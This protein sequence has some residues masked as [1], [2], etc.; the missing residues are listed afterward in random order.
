MNVILPKQYRVSKTDIIIYTVAIVV[1]VVALTVIITMQFLGEGIFHKNQ[2]Q[3]ATEEEMLKLKTEFDNMFSNQFEGEEEGFKK[4]DNSKAV[5]FTNYENTNNVEGDYTLNVHI[6]EINSEDENLLKLNKEISETYKE[7][8]SKILTAK[9]KQMIY[10]V[11]Y[12]S[13]IENK[14]L[15]LIIRSN[16]KQGNQAQ[17]TVLQ[18]Y[19]YDLEKK[20]M[21]NLEE[22]L[23]KLNY[24]KNDVQEKINEEIV[25]EEKNSKNLQELGYAIYVRDSE[26]DIYNI[27]NTKQFFIH[28]GKLYIIYCYGNY[29]L[30]SEMDFIVL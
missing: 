7:Q 3:I 21:I 6:P 12:I 20:K 24:Q 25:K 29:D 11:Q 16:I 13:H 22:M 26:S 9:G 5:V 2:I 17:K 23:T 14:I 8:T 15:T 27:E 19:N 18:T 30:T 1:C 4:K 28:N 10:S